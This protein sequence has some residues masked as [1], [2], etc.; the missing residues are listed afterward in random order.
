QFRNAA[1]VLWIVD[2]R[3]VESRARELLNASVSAVEHSFHISA[4]HSTED[5]ALLLKIEQT[6]PAHI[7]IATAG[8]TQE[9]LGAYL[10]NYLLYRPAIHCVGAGVAFLTGLERPIPRWAEAAGIGWLFRFISQP[11]MILPRIGICFALSRMLLRH[12]AELPPLQPR[13]ADL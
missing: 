3:E 12:R 1:K 7:I 10:R 8:G 6:R 4:S 5:H 11:G 2:S 9:K 13:W